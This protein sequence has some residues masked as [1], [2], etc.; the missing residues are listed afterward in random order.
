MSIQ[1]VKSFFNISSGKFAKK[2]IIF[3]NNFLLEIF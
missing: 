3:L 1:Q 2:I